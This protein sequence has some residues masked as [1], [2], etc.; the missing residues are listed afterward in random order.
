M[1]IVPNPEFGLPANQLKT[2][3]YWSYGYR[4]SD[5]CDWRQY[6]TDKGPMSIPS[7]AEEAFPI[8]KERGYGN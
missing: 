6:T 8:P 3:P 4:G 5:G 2:W 1:K 7:Y